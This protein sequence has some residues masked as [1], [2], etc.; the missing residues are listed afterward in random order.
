MISVNPY[1]KYKSLDTLVSHELLNEPP[2]IF[3]PGCLLLWTLILDISYDL[4]FTVEVKTW[5]GF[6]AG[7]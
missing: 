4:D 3:G 6:F 2:T 1:G 5:E 7:F